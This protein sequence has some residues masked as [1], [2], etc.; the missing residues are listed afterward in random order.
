MDQVSRTPKQLGA[1]LR[2]YRKQG[3][4]TQASLAERINKRQATVSS[5]ESVGGGTLETLFAI[6]SALDLELVVR[7]R[8]K[9]TTDQLGDIF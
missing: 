3:G 2:R 8:T 9:S 4:S 1:T 6:L 5:L 7:P